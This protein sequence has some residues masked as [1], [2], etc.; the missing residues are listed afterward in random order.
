MLH[1]ALKANALLSVA[2]LL[3]HGANVDLPDAQGD[4]AVHALLKLPSRFWSDELMAK[5]LKASA[6]LN[7]LGMHGASPLRLATTHGH[8]KAAVELLRLGADPRVLDEQQNSLLHCAAWSNS[9]AMSALFPALAGEV[10][11][12]S[13]VR[14]DWWGLVFYF[15][16]LIFFF[17]VRRHCL[18]PCNN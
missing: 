15:G 16:R 7:V 3:D 12:P 2:A 9:S 5:I 11:A 18:A 6:D 14:Q 8:Y 13:K 1:V 10:N 17:L 4:T